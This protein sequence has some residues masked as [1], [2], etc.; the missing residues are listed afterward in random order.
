MVGIGIKAL[1]IA[2][3][4]SRESDAKNEQSQIE[5]ENSQKKQVIGLAAQQG[6]HIVFGE[7]LEKLEVNKLAWASIYNGMTNS[8]PTILIL[9][10]TIDQKTRIVGF[11]YFI[12]DD[13]NDYSEKLAKYNNSKKHLIHALIMSDN[14]DDIG[15]IDPEPQSQITPNSQPQTQSVDQPVSASKSE[16]V[17]TSEI[18]ETKE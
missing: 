3:E 10:T 9:A 6:D 8:K 5:Y 13:L 11:H 7:K 18:K 2:S 16:P 1:S 14:A 17:K 4:S 15:P 12:F